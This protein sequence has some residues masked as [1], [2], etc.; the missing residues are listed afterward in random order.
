MPLITV[1]AAILAAQAAGADAAGAP[2]AAAIQK[3]CVTCHND[4]LKTGGLTLSSL[5]VT[6][7]SAH[8][9]TW[10]KV[11]R[12]LRTGSMPPPNAPRPD[13]S[14]YDTLAGYLETSIDRDAL[15]SPVPGKL[16]AVHRLSRTEYQHAIRDLLALDNLPAEIDY[17]LLLPADNSS[18][19]FDNL[20]D[21]LFV[22]PAIM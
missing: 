13:A 12:K 11:I 7:P 17:P 22:S 10:E 3:Y 21:L 6:R 8:A 1:A 14:T 20:A 9:D 2:A 15:R 19:G 5:D 18:S 4:R 16:P